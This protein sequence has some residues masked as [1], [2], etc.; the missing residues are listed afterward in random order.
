MEKSIFE[1]FYHPGAPEG[2]KC[3]YCKSSDTNISQGMWAHSLTVDDYQDLVERGW[4]RSGKYCYKPLLSKTCCPMYAIYCEAT[5]FRLSKSQKTVLKKFAKYLVEGAGL[6]EDGEAAGTTKITSSSSSI[7]AVR[8]PVQPGKGIDP[9]KPP[10]RKAKA[11]RKEMREKKQLSV[12]AS[13]KVGG[14]R[15]EESE[16]VA[17]QDSR[18]VPDF[19]KVGAD[20]KKPLEAFFQPSPTKP[21]APN[22]HKLETKIVRSSPPSDEFKATFAEAYSL[23]RKYQMSVHKETEEDVKESGFKRFLCDSPLVPRKGQDGWPCD[24]GSYHQQYRIDGKLVAVGVFDILP[25]CLS[26]VYVFYDPDSSF[27]SLGVYSACRELELTRKLHLGDPERFKYYC[28]GYYIHS[29]PKMRYKGEYSPSFLLC[30]ESYRFVPIERCSP[31]LDVNKYS[32]F[33][34]EDFTPEDVEQWISQVLVLFERTYM[35]YEQFR[36]FLPEPLWQV[37]KVKEYATLV[38]CKVASRA[39]LVLEKES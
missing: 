5:K 15:V 10:C 9:S 29:C 35:S 28:M 24:Y 32:R 30:P 2:H 37:T 13:S 6:K 4:R 14:E 36:R 27:L 22:A 18:T 20:G 21:G 19:M 1:Y 12:S 8:K 38:G 26:S 34:D 33:N 11:L 39:L 16:A 17:S 31:K 7:P 25:K 3:G 23:F